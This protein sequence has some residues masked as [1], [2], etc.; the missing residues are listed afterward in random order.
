MLLSRTALAGLW[1]Q[2][3]ITCFP[4]PLSRSGV[5]WGENVPSTAEDTTAALVYISLI[6]SE[7]PHFFHVFIGYLNFFRIQNVN[8]Y[9]LSRFL[10]GFCPFVYL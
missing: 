6:S 2:P 8:A 10:L 9:H 3:Q 5:I 1:S 7:A 4:V